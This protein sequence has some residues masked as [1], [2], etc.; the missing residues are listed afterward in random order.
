MTDGSTQNNYT[1]LLK[2]KRLVRHNYTIIMAM[3]NDIH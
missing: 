3:H 2:S 1:Y